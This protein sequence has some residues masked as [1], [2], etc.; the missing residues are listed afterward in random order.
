MKSSYFDGM[1]FILP[2]VPEYKVKSDT[3]II[4]NKSNHNFKEK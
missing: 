1:L 2:C 4:L 3:Y